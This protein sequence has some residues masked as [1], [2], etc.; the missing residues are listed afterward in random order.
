MFGIKLH[1]LKEPVIRAFRPR[2][3]ERPEGPLIEALIVSHGQP[4]DPEAGEKQLAAIAD[5]VG[6][7]LPNWDIRSATLAAPDR[8]EETLE[9]FSGVPYVFPM[10]MADGWFTK[11]ALPERLAG[12]SVHQLSP[13]GVHPGLPHKTFKY[14]KSVAAA[15]NWTFNSCEVMIAAHGSSTSSAAAECAL[16]FAK[17]IRCLTPFKKKI[18]TGFLAQRPFLHEVARVS[19]PRT[20]LLPFLAGSGPHLTEDIPEELE[21][22]RFLGLL[23]PAIGEADFVPG[24]IA[25]ALKSAELRSLAA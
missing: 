5:K 2:V 20:L 8:L 7:L 14:L 24:L 22:G 3:I 1:S 17:R 18:H 4:L 13:L 15:R 19:T 11:T 10:F 9:G 16:Y 21:K 23:L 25:H 12:R 6:A